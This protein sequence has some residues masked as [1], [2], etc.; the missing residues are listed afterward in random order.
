MQWETLIVIGTQKCIGFNISDTRKSFLFVAMSAQRLIF[1][2]TL[3]LFLVLLQNS[4]HQI[5]F[6]IT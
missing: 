2:S 4:E 1:C 5:I 6:C 3:R